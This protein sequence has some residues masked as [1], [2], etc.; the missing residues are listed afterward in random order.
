MKPTKRQREIAAKIADGCMW[1]IH[2][3][4]SSILP[5]TVPDTVKCNCMCPMGAALKDPRGSRYPVHSNLGF[6]KPTEAIDFMR[7]FDSGVVG[8]SFFSKLG[9][10]YRAWSKGKYNW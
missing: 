8:Q 6:I 10:A 9:L 7:A 2:S 4:G 1:A 3:F 5:N